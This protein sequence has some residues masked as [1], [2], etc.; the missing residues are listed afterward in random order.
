MNNQK[1]NYIIITLINFIFILSFFFY[2]INF[3]QAF[4]GGIIDYIG[5]TFM[6]WLFLQ[7]FPFISCLI[8]ALLRYYGIKNKNNRLYRLNQVYIY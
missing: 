7:V 8:S 2:I 6:T 1:C 4:K 3:S 5:A